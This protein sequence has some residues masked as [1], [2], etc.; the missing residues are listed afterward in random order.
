[1]LRV[2]ETPWRFTSPRSAPNTLRALHR[3]YQSSHPTIA[4]C[5]SSPAVPM[6]SGPPV[7]DAL[8][9]LEMAI[10]PQSVP[11]WLSSDT[12][13][14]PKITALGPRRSTVEYIDAPTA[15]GSGAAGK[16]ARSTTAAA[17]GVS[18]VGDHRNVEPANSGPSLS[19]VRPRAPILMQ[20][21]AAHEG[22]FLAKESDHA[23]PKRSRQRIRHQTN[24]TK[25]R[26]ALRK[27]SDGP[28]A[29]VERSRA[30]RLCCLLGA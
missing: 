2:P 24:G 14:A 29:L 16:G 6:E 9:K 20:K 17:A 5:R 28:I 8:S 26:Y 22:D 10:R 19:S 18:S 25:S 13:H 21:D 23:A 15:S 4:Y 3:R 7:L 11:S 30:E 12:N 1:M 27:L